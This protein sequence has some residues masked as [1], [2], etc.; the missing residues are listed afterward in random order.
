MF[1]FKKE[2]KHIVLKVFGIKISLN[3]PSNKKK[4]KE[5]IEHKIAPKTV[6]LVEL[7]I[8]H[9]ET[10]T[11][12]YAY[13]KKLG[14]NVEVLV[15]P[16]LEGLFDKL[17][18]DL[19]VWEFH[20]KDIFKIFKNFDFRKYECVI[21]NS[22]LIYPCYLDIV[23]YLPKLPDCKKIY[24]QHHID[25]FLEHVNDKQIILANP[26]GDERLERAVVN[27]HYFGE[28]AITP[29]NKITEFITIGELNPERKNCSLLIDAVSELV[30]NGVKNFK[31][32][33]V[34]KG[35]LKD[36]PQK[37][38]PYIDIKGRLNFPKMIKEIEKADYIL[39]LLDPENKANERYKKSGT[40]GSFQ[41]VY[42]FL[43]P[44]LIHRVFADI[45]NFNDKNALIYENNKEI[46]NVMK[47]AIQTSAQEYNQI[48]EELKIKVNAIEEVSL[49]NLKEMLNF[50]GVNNG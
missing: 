45:Y 31:I 10:L 16:P 1:Y 2:Y 8:G 34:G 30:E 38:K 37:I 6:L 15:H 49:S 32:C 12:Y 41:V 39:P 33:V 22:R 35:S 24:V 20:E 46:A 40:S 14:Y 21:F 29:K 44:C 48:Q 3:Y 50:E 11:G 28:V 18:K 36:I 9:K 42:G 5:F 47:K 43:K 7:N 19:K 13:L 23:E 25:K 27:P 4:L 17:K 26:A